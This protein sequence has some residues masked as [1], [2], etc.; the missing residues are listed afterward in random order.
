MA[1][2]ES[3]VGGGAVKPKKDH[4]H[5]DKQAPPSHIE[6]RAAERPPH[7]EKKTIRRKT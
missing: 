4:P 3:F 2:V 6:K 1:P 5:Q 7:D